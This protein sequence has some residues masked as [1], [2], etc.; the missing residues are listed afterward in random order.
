MASDTEPHHQAAN[1]PAPSSGPTSLSMPDEEQVRRWGR[2]CI[3]DCM[4]DCGFTKR[5]RDVGS[6]QLGLMWQ[7]LHGAALLRQIL[8]DQEPQDFHIKFWDLVRHL[9]MLDKTL[10]PET[11]SSHDESQ[12]RSMQVTAPA[13]TGIVSS[14]QEYWVGEAPLSECLL[15]ILCR[16]L[17]W[18]S[19]KS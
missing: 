19:L 13:K 12:D 18:L 1:S 6:R 16:G 3:R 9:E 15:H 14:H 8:Q 7:S 10:E 4:V 5:D 11:S 17:N 2:Q